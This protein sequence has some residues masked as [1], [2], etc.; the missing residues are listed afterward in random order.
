MDRKIISI[1]LDTEISNEEIAK[2]LKKLLENWDINFKIAIS[3][4]E[5]T[6]YSKSDSGEIEE[7]KGVINNNNS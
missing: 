2:E 4:K 1:T 7:K 6:I 3:S 5:G